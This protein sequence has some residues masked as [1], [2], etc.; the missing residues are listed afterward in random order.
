M[1]T[2]SNILAWEIPCT[3]ELAGYSLWGYKRV[4][5]TDR[6]TENYV[7]CLVIIYSGKQS[8]K[9]TYNQKKS[10]DDMVLECGA[11]W[12]DKPACLFCDLLSV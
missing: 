2:H 3:E 5:L 7:L 9:Y 12:D 6:T 8:D 11:T 1:A 10:S 4:G